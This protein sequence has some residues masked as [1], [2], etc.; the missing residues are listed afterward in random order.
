MMTPEQLAAAP[1]GR[2][3]PVCSKSAERIAARLIY[4]QD[5]EI[6]PKDALVCWNCNVYRLRGGP[7]L[8]IDLRRHKQHWATERKSWKSAS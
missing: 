3:C 8:S 1:Q 4:P 2:K 6:W 5:Q 7:W